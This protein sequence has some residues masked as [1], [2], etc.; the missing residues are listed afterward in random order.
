MCNG[1]N[2]EI[3]V[4]GVTLLGDAIHA[5]PPSRGSGGN[6]AL[7]DASLLSRSLITVARQGTPLRQAL[8]DY[9]IEMVHYGFDAV[10]ASMQGGSQG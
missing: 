4:I 5:M 7:R 8:H 3:Q 10:R 1:G 2:G 6:T 9:E